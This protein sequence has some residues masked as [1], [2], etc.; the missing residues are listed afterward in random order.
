MLKNRPEEQEVREQ[1]GTSTSTRDIA[2][3]QA[4]RCQSTVDI[5]QADD[6]WA[7]AVSEGRCGHGGGRGCKLGK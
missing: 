3:Y 1:L 2:S 7:G 4:S 5:E 6:V